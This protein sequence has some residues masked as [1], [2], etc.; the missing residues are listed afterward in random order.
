MPTNLF[1]QYNVKPAIAEDH[2]NLYY[3]D[4][5]YS[6]ARKIDITNP[7]DAALVRDLGIV[8]EQALRKYRW[9]AASSNNLHWNGTDKPVR[10]VMVPYPGLRENITLVNPEITG[11]GSW[12]ISFI[13]GCAS[14]PGRLYVVKRRTFAELSAHL[15]TETGFAPVHFEYGIRNLSDQDLQKPQSDLEKKLI[16]EQLK[17]VSLVQHEIDHLDGIVIAEKGILYSG[18]DKEKE[19]RALAEL[20]MQEMSFS[21]Y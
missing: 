17:D 3:R 7:E 4:W 2:K 14:F 6:V 16:S 18:S 12:E 20:T 5:V 9:C 8:M 21:F 15:L 19:R 11:Y 1:K 13:E 10:V